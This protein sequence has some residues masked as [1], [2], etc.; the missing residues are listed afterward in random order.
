MKRPARLPATPDDLAEWTVYA[1]WLQGEGDPRG[2]VIAHALAGSAAGVIHDHAGID[3]VTRLGFIHSVV[4]P[5]HTS[6]SVA[7]DE[8]HRTASL[9]GSD[10]AVL[11]EELEVPL[12]PEWVEDMQRVFA[13]LPVTCRRVAIDLCN[14]ISDGAAGALLDALPGHVRE[15]ALSSSGTRLRIVGLT[16][17]AAWIDDRFDAVELRYTRST[18]DVALQQ[19][20]ADRDVIA[21]RLAATMRVRLQLTIADT[22][23]PVDRVDI[24]RPGDAAIVDVNRR[25]A[26]ALSTR[27][28]DRSSTGGIRSK[29]A[30]GL[31]A[32]RRLV[33]TAG[34]AKIIVKR[35]GD[36]WWLENDWSSNAPVRVEGVEVAR[37]AAVAVHDGARIA[38]D[39]WTYVLITRDVTATVRSLLA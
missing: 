38:S 13:A 6:Y 7:S 34:W 5:R 19:M 23:Y 14:P 8:L 1:D 37:R 16:G 9:V 20:A 21:K 25:C 3:V 4:V 27:A 36:D 12:E 31:Y 24:G 18:W 26:M 22:P 35:D 39:D 11:L 2:E 30:V 33:V 10:D 28:S 17:L 32:N 15:V 29:F